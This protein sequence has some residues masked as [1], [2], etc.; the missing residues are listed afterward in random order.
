MIG[1]DTPEICAA[2]AADP[3]WQAEQA[4]KREAASARFLAYRASVGMPIERSKTSRVAGNG[5][6]RDRSA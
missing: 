5:Y 2:R 4:D 1:V 3:A 6:G